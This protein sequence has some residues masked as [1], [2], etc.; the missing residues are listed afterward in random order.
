[1]S[2]KKVLSLGQCSADHYS[3]SSLLHRQLGAEVVA[4]DTFDAAAAELR[5]G[6]FDLVLVNRV[7]NRDG[8]SGLEAIAELK[9]DESLAQV[10]VMLVSNHRDAQEQAAALGALPGFGKSSLGSPQTVARL[11]TALGGG[12][13]DQ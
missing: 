10:P 1:M 9:R 12:R 6:G 4:V 8:S 2:T 11:R 5:R 7:L 13:A 3:I